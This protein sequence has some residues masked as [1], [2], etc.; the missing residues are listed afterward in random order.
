MP[1]WGVPI[2]TQE[3]AADPTPWGWGCSCSTALPMSQGRFLRVLKHTEENLLLGRKTLSLPCSPSSRKKVAQM[4]AS[5]R[6]FIFSWLFACK[7][8][9]EGRVALTA[10]S[11][12]KNLLRV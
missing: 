12:I 9:A 8:P 3:H 1:I 4:F 5:P 11:D 6:C 10:T 2:Q 7:G